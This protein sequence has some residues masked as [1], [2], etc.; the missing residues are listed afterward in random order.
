LLAA[1]VPDDPE[2]RTL[3]S[4]S[5]R[6]VKLISQL[7]DEKG[8]LYGARCSV[9]LQKRRHTCYEC[10]DVSDSE[11][12]KLTL[13]RKRKKKDEQLPIEMTV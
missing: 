1:P 11:M 2:R 13:S 3:V 10:F 5:Y 9:C 4:P 12:E 6:S 7:V 8:R